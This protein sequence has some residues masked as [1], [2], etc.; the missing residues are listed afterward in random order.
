MASRS[1]AQSCLADTAVDKE[2]LGA[3]GERTGLVFPVQVRSQV[4]VGSTLGED[5]HLEC[6][7]DLTARCMVDL[8]ERP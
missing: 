4:Q 8:E 3:F 6:K 7:V 5:S 1:R 2:P